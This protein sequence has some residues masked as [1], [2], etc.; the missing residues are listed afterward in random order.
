M[1]QQTQHSKLT[2]LPPQFTAKTTL[3]QPPSE[4]SAT[5]P[6][7]TQPSASAHPRPQHSA[8]HLAFKQ[9][10]RLSMMSKPVAEDLPVSSTAPGRSDKSSTADQVLQD[11]HCSFPKLA[12]LPCLPCFTCRNDMTSSKEPLGACSHSCSLPVCPSPPTLAGVCSISCLFCLAHVHSGLT[13]LF[14]TICRHK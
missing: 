1:V 8:P 6:S 12:F 14:Y 13:A 7:V 4:P 2:L 3:P 9:H 11:Q 10:S 5:T